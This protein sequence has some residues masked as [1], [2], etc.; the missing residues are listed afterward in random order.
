MLAREFDGETSQLLREILTYLLILLGV[1]A[2]VFGIT[3]LANVPIRLFYDQK[4]LLIFALYLIP[5]WAVIRLRCCMESADYLMMISV[6]VGIL[7]MCYIM[8]AVISTGYGS[9]SELGVAA[10]LAILPCFYA[11]VFSSPASSPKKSS[12]RNIYQS[13]RKRSSNFVARPHRGKLFKRDV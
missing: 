2:L 7:L 10:S 5:G 4:T 13:K 12:K 1:S 8:Q 6:P 9:G 3:R 11:G